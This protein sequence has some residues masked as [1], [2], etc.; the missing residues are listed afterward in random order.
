MYNRYAHRT[1]I[2]KELWYM[3]MCLDG[4]VTGWVGRGGVVGV[5]L[6]HVEVVAPHLWPRADIPTEG[7]SDR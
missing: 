6:A 7:R 1:R 3:P 5:V 2:L 4:W